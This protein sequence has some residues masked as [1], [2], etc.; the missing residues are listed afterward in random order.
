M[1]HPPPATEPCHVTAPPRP[2]RRRLPPPF[3]SRR[4][5]A[6]RLQ[7]NPHP[8]I[9]TH[10]IQSTNLSIKL[11]V[12]L[13]QRYLDE[14]HTRAWNSSTSLTLSA[15]LQGNRALSRRLAATPLPPPA[16]SPLPPPATA[17]ATSPHHREADGCARMER[18]RRRT[19]VGGKGGG[20]IDG[21]GD[22]DPEGGGRPSTLPSRVRG[23]L[24]DAAERVT[25]SRK[26]RRWPG[27]APCE[28][29]ARRGKAPY[30]STLGEG[31]GDGLRRWR[32]ARVMVVVGAGFGG[33]EDPPPMRV[34]PPPIAMGGVYP[35][36]T[37]AV[38]RQ[39]WRKG[40][41]WPPR[42]PPPPA[43]IPP[44]LRHPRTRIRRW[45]Q[46]EGRMMAVAVAGQG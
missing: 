11:A 19:D 38:R 33:D 34:D 22:L 8:Q 21:R 6:Q 32:W 7:I 14:H 27:R 2:R 15:P 16:P 45:R 29:A 25:P 46:W 4:L 26:G 23:G 36:S 20:G 41:I 9:T 13:A 3:P 42:T 37:R 44:P 5:P 12:A 40:W 31:E 43:W 17:A 24:G 1:P 10:N 18:R 39:Q 35:A 28:G 30:E